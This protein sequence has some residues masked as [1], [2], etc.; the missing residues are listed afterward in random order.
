MCHLAQYQ[1][2]LNAEASPARS[3][4]SQWQNR[5]RKCRAN[6]WFA[7]NNM[8]QINWCLLMSQAVIVELGGKLM[9]GHQQEPGQGGGSVL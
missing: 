7:S 4:Q 1:E 9:D 2:H 8:P 3:W 6:T 5:M